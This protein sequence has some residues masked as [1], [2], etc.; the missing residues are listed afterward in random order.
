MLF[1]RY[2]RWLA[3]VAAALTGIP[4]GSIYAWSVYVD[5]IR[6]AKPDPDWEDAGA[7]ATSVVICALALSCAISGRVADRSVSISLLCS[8]GA[9]LSGLGFILGG[10]SIGFPHGP[11][12]LFYGAPSCTSTIT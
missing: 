6:R 7:H 8:W 11:V 5:P 12:S 4:V 2:G 1:E 9:C 10:L 3:L